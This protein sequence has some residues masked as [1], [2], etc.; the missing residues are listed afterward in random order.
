ME[1]INRNMIQKIYALGATDKQLSDIIGVTEQTLNNWKKS[2]PQF[3]ESIK[4]WKEDADNKVERSL[5]QRA[6]GYEYEEV[7]KEISMRTK[8]LKI[9][10]IV[11]KKTPASEIACIFWL[12]N[13]R[14]LDWRD[15]KEVDVKF[16]T[17]EQKADSLGKIEEMLRARSN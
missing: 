12:K 5:Y 15:K 8:K 1:T 6:L 17:P 11:T 3:F 13:R 2:D 14:P 16:L 4:G 10:K 9:T 7:T